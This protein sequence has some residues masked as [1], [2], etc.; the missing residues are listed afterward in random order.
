MS[1]SCPSLSHLTLT[2]PPSPPTSS[3]ST[4]HSF[5]PR[6]A[7]TFTDD[8]EN[9]IEYTRIF[10]E[11]TRLVEG[12][13]E[14]KLSAKLRDFRMADFERMVAGRQDEVG[15]EIF[16]M[17]LSFTDFSEFKAQILAY[18]AAMAPGGLG[19]VQGLHLG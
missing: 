14:E 7:Y 8:E 6:Y 2:F 1:T 5:P 13:L 15:G 11:Y 4:P 18:K 16:D 19:G 12:T 10:Q 17:L 3:L 9:K